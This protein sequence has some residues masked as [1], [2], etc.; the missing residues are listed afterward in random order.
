MNGPGSRRIGNRL[1]LVAGAVMFWSAPAPAAE[2]QKWCSSSAKKQYDKVVEHLERIQ[3][4]HHS[5]GTAVRMHLEKENRRV[6]IHEMAH[7]EKAGRWGK[8]PTYH[9]YTHEGH[10][11]A[12]SGCVNI[13][14]GAP[15]DVIIESALAPVDP[16]DTDLGLAA[17]A[18]ETLLAEGKRPK[19]CKAGTYKAYWGL[20]GCDRKLS[21][22]K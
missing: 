20:I 5:Y 21:G 11:Y 22:K 12:I 14:R 7:K 13:K 1:L 17:G 8:E 19:A 2:K 6:V 18:A 9:Y 10:R 15:A 3:K 4:Q 16:S